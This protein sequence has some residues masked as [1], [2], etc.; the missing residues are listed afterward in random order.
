MTETNNLSVEQAVL[1]EMKG[2]SLD[3]GPGIR[4]VVFF[5]GCPLSCTWCHNPESQSRQ[6]QLSFDESKCV[7]I[8]ECM[9][10]CSEGALDKSNPLF[11]DHDKCTTCFKCTEVCAS[12]ALSIM[13]DCYTVEQVLAVVDRYQVFYETSGGGVTLSGGEFTLYPKFCEQLLSKLKER[14]IHTLVET[15][16]YFSMTHFERHMLPYIDQI[17]MDIKLFDEQQHITYCG[18]SNSRILENF[19]ILNQRYQNG[20]VP[21]LPRVP[22]IPGITATDENLSAIATFLKQQHVTRL[23]V[24]P[25]NPMWAS[26]ANK[27]G[28]DIM[29][30][31]EKWMSAEEV[32]HCRSFFSDFELV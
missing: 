17:Y 13:G 9:T 6:A 31:N 14:G 19:S 3:D 27:I 4:T 8:G 26:K 32:A 2:N 29:Y 28:S 12:E 1:C 30:H 20:G 15:S 11:I 10:V 7:G 21:I 23:S 18:K 16:G 22:L 25:Y 24:L 5:K